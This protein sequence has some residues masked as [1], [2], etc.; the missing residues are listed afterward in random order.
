MSIAELQHAAGELAEQERAAFAL[1]LLETLPP[2]G[3][4]DGCLEGIAEAVRR[5]DELDSGQSRPL[6]A[7][8]FWASIDRERLA[9]K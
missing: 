9:W 8:E 4:E 6:A 7:E 2:H 1:W 5:R 3:G